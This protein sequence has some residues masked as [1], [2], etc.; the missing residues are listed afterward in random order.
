MRNQSQGITPEIS[1]GSTPVFITETDVSNYLKGNI[2]LLSYPK[3]ARVK[4]IADKALRLLSVIARGAYTHDGL[5][6][7][8]QSFSNADCVAFD[9][10]A[11]GIRA[12][13]RD[14]ARHVAIQPQ[15]GEIRFEPFGV[16]VP[17]L[18]LS[19]AW[20]GE[21]I[22]GDFARFHTAS[23]ASDNER[24]FVLA[25][26]F[27]LC[28]PM[29]ANEY[30]REDLS[31]IC[32]AT[33]DRL[34]D[35]WT[36]HN[37]GLDVAAFERLRGIFYALRE[38]AR[39]DSEDRKHWASPMVNVERIPAIARAF[40]WPEKFSQKDCDDICS[41]LAT[42]SRLF[43]R[44]LCRFALDGKT[45]PPEELKSWKEPQCFVDFL[46]ACL[47]SPYELM[48]AHNRAYSTATL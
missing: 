48:K 41:A 7:Y 24:H 17:A 13:M 45:L 12:L 28:H 16:N 34:Q 5:L 25:A 6:A 11:D 14:A 40:L 35:S 19:E 8:A 36:R 42:A 32:L 1:Q 30:Q 10:F 9:E 44:E 15:S 4:A 27:A 20:G 38:V 39:L 3:A 47:P 31:R 18:D 22:G 2:D 21:I 43:D 37:G 23:F 26:R 33:L 29:K 46:A